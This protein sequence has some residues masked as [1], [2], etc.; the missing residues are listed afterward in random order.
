[1]MVLKQFCSDIPFHKLLIVHFCSFGILCIQ[2]Q[3]DQI[4][5]CAFHASLQKG[6]IMLIFYMLDAN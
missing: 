1:M 3:I 5:D 6:K 2:E 4:A